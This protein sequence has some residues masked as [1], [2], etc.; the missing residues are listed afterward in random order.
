[1]KIRLIRIIQDFPVEKYD[2]KILIKFWIGN[3]TTGDFC[4]RILRK[5]LAVCSG[6]AKTRTAEECGFA[7]DR[8]IVRLI[9]LRCAIMQ[10]WKI[11]Q[12]SP[13][14]NTQRRGVDAVP[15]TC[16]MIAVAIITMLTIPIATTCPLCHLQAPHTA[17]SCSGRTPSQ[18]PVKARHSPSYVAWCGNG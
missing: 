7:R 5:I 6:D 11:F 14:T 17:L 15:I 16:V 3:S 9:L 4:S 1:M 10:T 18:T 12:S 8:G 13:E 2:W